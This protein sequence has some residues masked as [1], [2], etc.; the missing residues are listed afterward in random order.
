VDDEDKCGC[1]TYIRVIFIPRDGSTTSTT[2]P[3]AFPAPIC[4]ASDL[5]T[6]DSSHRSIDAASPNPSSQSTDRRRLQR[7]P[8]HPSLQGGHIKRHRGMHSCG[9]RVLYA[10]VSLRPCHGCGAE[11]PRQGAFLKQEALG[12]S[13]AMP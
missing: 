9:G 3:L 6:R 13:S 4:G 5:P 11:G 8:P 10:E 12:A 1:R 2:M 7:A